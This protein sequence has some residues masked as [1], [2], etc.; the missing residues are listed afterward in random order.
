MSPRR[1]HS[2]GS[3]ECTCL[4]CQDWRGDA[5]YRLDQ[6]DPQ[7]STITAP[8]GEIFEADLATLRSIDWAA[9]GHYRIDHLLD[10]EIQ[11]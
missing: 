8:N 10:R 1:F 7:R 3:P 11:T 5:G 4:P 9:I 2:G 6:T